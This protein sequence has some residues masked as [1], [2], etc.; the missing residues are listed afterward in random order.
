MKFVD[1]AKYKFIIEPRYYFYGW[2]NS[3]RIL[4][5][6]SVVK[7]LVKARS[8]LPE[9]YNFKIWDCK[10]SL[11]TNVEM[12]KS[13]RRRLRLMY[14][15]ASLKKIRKILV[16]FCGRIPCPVREKHLDT[17]RR[18]GAVDLIIVDKGG[19]ELYMGKDF[20][21]LTPKAATDF[22]ENKKQLTA[23]EK[24][25]RKNRRLLKRVMTRAGF[26]NYPVEWWHW[27]FNK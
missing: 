7:A 5:R 20:D 14:P 2:S 15:K 13:F 1:L 23:I 16:T 26:K 9:G 27:S 19:N 12:V 21:D 24:I 18:G 8:F 22:F 4:V 3:P 11:K 10:R 25:A 17:H 6:Q